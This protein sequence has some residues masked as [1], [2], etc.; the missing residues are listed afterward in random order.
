MATYFV[1][2]MAS[3]SRVLYTGMT[4]NLERRVFEHKNRLVPGFSATYHCKRLV[5]FEEGNEV[6]SAIEREKQIK[7]WSRAKKIAL[8]Q[9]ANPAW[10]DL[11]DGWFENQDSSLRSE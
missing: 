1:Y 5:Y 10:N 11:S 3:N 7:S 8:I 4:N 2:I 6:R 9:R